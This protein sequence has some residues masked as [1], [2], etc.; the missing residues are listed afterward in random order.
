MHMLYCPNSIKIQRS[1]IFHVIAAEYGLLSTHRMAMSYTKR[2]M[3]H[4]YVVMHSI[5]RLI[6]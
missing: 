3:W 4:N 1:Y 2:I 6:N 5:T